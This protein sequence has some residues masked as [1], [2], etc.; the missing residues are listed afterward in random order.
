MPRVAIFG[1]LVVNVFSVFMSALAV[2]LLMLVVPVLV[3][4][5]VLFVSLDVQAVSAR[6][7]A[8][9]NAVVNRCLVIV[10][11]LAL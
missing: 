2:E 7:R 9:A 11:F 6:P 4:L 3:V 1:A 5:L 8:I 10:S